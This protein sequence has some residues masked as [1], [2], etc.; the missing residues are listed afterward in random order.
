MSNYDDWEAVALMGHHPTERSGL[1]RFGR[2]CCSLQLTPE[3]VDDDVVARF[4]QHLDLNQLSKT[5]IASGV[6]CRLQQN[7]PRR[8]VRWVCLRPAGATCDPM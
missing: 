7:L 1:R 4:Y 3:A 8:R 5:P 2:F 6:S